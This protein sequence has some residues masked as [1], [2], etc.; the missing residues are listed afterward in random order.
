MWDSH[1]SFL[2]EVGNDAEK[3]DQGTDS[4]DGGDKKCGTHRPASIP[5]V[6]SPRFFGA[7][8]IRFES[9]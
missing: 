2:R 6:K 8:G 7:H 1:G 3:A 9:D 4:M 5:D